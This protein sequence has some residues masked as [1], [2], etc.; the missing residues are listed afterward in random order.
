MDTKKL[1]KYSTI[2]LVA[3]IVLLFIVIVVY[4]IY[5]KV[6]PTTGK[7]AGFSAYKNLASYSDADKDPFAKFYTQNKLLADEFRTGSLTID[8]VTIVYSE[9]L[10][11]AHNGKA[12]NAPVT[13]VEQIQDLFGFIATGQD[14]TTVK[15]EAMVMVGQGIISI[16]RLCDSY[17]SQLPMFKNK[18]GG[19]DAAASKLYDDYI[20]AGT[21]RD[22]Q[23]QEY[24]THA[25]V[26]DYSSNDATAARYRQDIAE[27]LVISSALDNTDP[28]NVMREGDYQEYWDTKHAGTKHESPKAVY[29][30]IDKRYPGT[31]D[32]RYL[33]DEPYAPW[34]E[35]PKDPNV[36]RPGIIGRVPDIQYHYDRQAGIYH[37]NI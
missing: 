36:P 28:R 14:F 16:N 33:D 11:A 31:Y 10:D 21:P 26:E 19:T 27:D 7:F 8:K 32:R 5:K 1:L 12:D 22:G 25:R 4:I 3:V 18:L 9:F 29:D 13:I 20:K 2:A 34:E 17:F 15:T 37:R 24:L 35:S 6:L 23:I 30:R